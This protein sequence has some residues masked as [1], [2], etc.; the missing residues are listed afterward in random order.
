M[1]YALVLLLISSQAAAFVHK[2]NI[3]PDIA[4]YNDY[5]IIESKSKKKLRIDTSCQFENIKEK[6]IKVKMDTRKLRTHSKL[7][8]FYDEKIQRCNVE[9]ITML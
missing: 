3:E 2:N 8:F 7:T 9:N 5:I 6:D 4:V 1:K